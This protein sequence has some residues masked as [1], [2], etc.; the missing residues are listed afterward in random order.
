MSSIEKIR[1][2]IERRM[3]ELARDKYIDLHDTLCRTKELNLLLTFIDSLLEDEPS[4]DLEEAADDYAD[5]HGFRVPYDGSNNYYDDVDVRA[6]KEGFIAGAEWQK[7]Q[8][9]SEMV[10]SRSPLSVAYANRCFENGKQ[11]MKEQMIKEAE[12]CDLYWDGDFLAID[13]NM[14]VLGYSEKDKVKIII[15]PSNDAD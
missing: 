1:Q 3:L 5:K 13:L 10:Q 7:K 8:D 6:S 9:L 11:A 15:L 4:K 12:E 2:E 14:R